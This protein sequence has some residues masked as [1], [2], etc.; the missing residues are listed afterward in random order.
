MQN[1][2]FAD[3][4]ALIIILNIH[5]KCIRA[6]CGI[7]IQIN[8][9]VLHIDAIIMCLRRIVVAMLCTANES[10]DIYLFSTCFECIHGAVI[11][12]AKSQSSIHNVYALAHKKC[13][14]N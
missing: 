9:I 6:G 11:H 2:L 3:G 1:N 14:I 12:Q 10:T 13:G 8:L 7:E 5:T 4:I